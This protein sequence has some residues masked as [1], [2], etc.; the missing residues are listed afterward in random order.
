MS[1]RPALL[2]L[3][4]AVVALPR[5][6]HALTV[7]AVTGLPLPE[8]DGLVMAVRAAQALLEEALL[9]NSLP[10]ERRDARAILRVEARASA[11][12]PDSFT[13]SLK[14][15]AADPAVRPHQPRG[16][17]M[18][19]MTV[20]DKITGFKGVVTGEVN[21]LTGC[22]QVLVA[23]PLGGDGALRGSEWFDVQ[24][25]EV[26]HAFPAIQLDN[27]PNPGCDRAPPKR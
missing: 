24:R 25:V 16:N 15:W 11:V 4:R 2:D 20:R 27:G 21:Y 8:T 22:N 10:T 9:H 17:D 7:G 19:G 5:A 18:L 12:A 14:G 13:E 6:A 3:I 23:P 26:D 1:V